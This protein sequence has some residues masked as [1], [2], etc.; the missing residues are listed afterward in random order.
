MSHTRRSLQTS[1]IEFMT[2][3]DQAVN[4]FDAKMITLYTGMQLEELSEKLQAIQG[5]CINEADRNH[6]K[7]VVDV[8][9]QLADEFKRG[10][11]LGD[12]LRCD[13]QQLLDADIDLA[14]V[15]LGAAFST[16]I[17]AEGAI[18]EVARSNLDKAPG[19]RVTRDAN[20]KVQ[21]PEGWSPPNLLPFVA[22]VE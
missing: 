19:G 1:V 8:L 15:S 18:D 14:W 4:K 21:K 17:D 9:E 13:Y 2:A 16:S 6:F 5:G 11:H 12:V 3:T 10:H 22:T 7:F 20:G